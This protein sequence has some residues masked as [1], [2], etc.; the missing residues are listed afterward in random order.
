MKKLFLAFLPAIL[1]L[2]SCSIGP[3]QNEKISFKEDT[4]AHEEIFGELPEFETAPNVLMPKRAIDGTVYAPVIGVQQKPYTESGNDYFAVRFVAAIQEGT[5]GATWRRSVHTLDG[6][7]IR[8]AANKEVH[9]YYVS[10]NEGD[11]E[12]PAVATTIEAYE[13]GNSGHFAYF[14]VYCLFGIP[15]ANTDY[16]VDAY[17]TISDGSTSKQSP[18]G[19]VNVADSSKK[20]RYE[21]GTSNRDVAAING[22]VVE[23]GDLG[24]NKVALYD[25]DLKQNDKIKFYWINKDSLTYIQNTSPSIAGSYQDDFSLANSE[26]TVLHN[27]KYKLFLSGGSGEDENKLWFQK[28]IYLSAPDWWGN[29]SATSYIAQNTVEDGSKV[30]TNVAMTWVKDLLSGNKLYKVYFDISN[31]DRMGFFRREPGDHDYN[32]SGFTM[33]PSDG[34]DLCT[35]VETPKSFTWSVYSAS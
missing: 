20:L 21:L 34:K 33:L 3:K 27:G 31:F 9:G 5:T 26:L 13:D 24:G 15:A 16:Y 10:L 28:E 17:V 30:S 8:E 12:H 25:I 23:S 32:W 4:L 35:Y 22:V 11:P 2:S 18:V 1:V 19:S 7:I 6:T 29:N 14:A